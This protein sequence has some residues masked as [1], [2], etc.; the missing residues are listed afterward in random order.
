[1]ANV[2]DLL[3]AEWRRLDCDRAAARRLPTVCAA[4]GRAWTLGE[5]ERFVRAA[6][7]ADADRVLLA[8][9]AL[10]VEGDQLAAR[11]LLQLL[12]PG[13]RALARRWWALGEPDERAAAAV[14]AVYH[15][16]CH[17]PLARRPGR[18]AA[19]VLLDAAQEL[20]RRVPR[21]ITVPAADPAAGRERGAAAAVGAEDAP[22][23]EGGAP[24]R[25]GSADGRA[26]TPNPAV[27]LAELLTDA[28]D[29]GI[30]DRDDAELI[31]RS[32]IAGHRVADIASQRGLRPRTLWDRRQRA[33]ST[34]VAALAAS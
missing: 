4:A 28:V 34:L 3:D 15:R 10:A 8:L 13:T 20:R 32:R 25:R 11:V 29:A 33:E 19:N 17:Y 21:L 27:E 9:V 30:V 14:T 18:V 23:R 24:A 6:H 2:F 7:P 31:A 16:I 26:E 22:G 5:V 1:M 12:L